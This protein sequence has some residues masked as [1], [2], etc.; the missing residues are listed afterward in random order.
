MTAFTAHDCFKVTLLFFLFYYTFMLQTY[1][2][3]FFAIIYFN[4][5]KTCKINLR[6][7]I[8]SAS[9]FPSPFMSN[10]FSLIPYFL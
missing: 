1:A 5:I 6:W 3:K 10:S 2:I 4:K 7:A 9:F 8:S